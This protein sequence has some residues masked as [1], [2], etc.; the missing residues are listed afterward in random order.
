M[1]WR[2]QDSVIRGEIDNRV[3]GRVRGKVWL[4]GLAEPVMLDLE[5]NACPDLA[6]CRLRFKGR[7]R[8]KVWLDGLAEPVMLDLEGN[9]CPDLAGCRLEFKNPAKTFPMR[10]KPE[11]NPLQRGNTSDLSLRQS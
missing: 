3:K 5:G 6:G 8:G 4:D 9:A 2:I 7:L 10:K 1:A 11:F